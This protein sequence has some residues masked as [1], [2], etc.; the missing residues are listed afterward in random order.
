MTQDGYNAYR[1]RLSQWLGIM[2]GGFLRY[3]FSTADEDSMDFS[4]LY[5]DDIV[6]SPIDEDGP[7]RLP[8]VSKTTLVEFLI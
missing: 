6:L 2:G 3:P 7:Q 8:I 1:K 4:S 5:D